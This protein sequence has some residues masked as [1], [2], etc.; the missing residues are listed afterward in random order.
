MK[1]WKM[2]QIERNSEGKGNNAMVETPNQWVN[3]GFR[4][5]NLSL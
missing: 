2:G 1:W 3:W 4:Q 5:N